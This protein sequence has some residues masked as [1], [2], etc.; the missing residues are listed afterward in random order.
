MESSRAPEQLLVRHLEHARRGGVERR[1]DAV[2]VARE[3]AV[4]DGV[5]RHGELVEGE[6]LL[7]ARAQAPEGERHVLREQVRDGLVLLAELAVAAQLVGVEHAADLAAADGDGE[8]RPAEGLA[9]PRREGAAGEGRMLGRLTASSLV[10]RHSSVVPRAALAGLAR[11][12]EAPAALD[13]HD[14][15]I[16]VEQLRRERRH[17]GREGG[18]VDA[19]RR[20]R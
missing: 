6:A 9:R 20:S 18:L 11:G 17:D 8:A 13:G 12:H 14:D 19:R 2:R 1:D 4:A 7:L 15:P 3:D 10:A 5:E 16:G